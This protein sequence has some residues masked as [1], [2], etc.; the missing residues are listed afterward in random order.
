MTDTPPAIPAATLVVFRDAGDGPP[1]LLF[2]ER[3]KAMAFAGGALV[4]PG[5]RVD[6]GDHALAAVLGTGD[7]ESAARIA[8]VRETIEEAG[9]PIGLSAMPSPTAFARMRAALHA[10]TAF[11]EALT[12]AAVGLDLDALEYFARWRPAHAHARIFDT[13][14][15]LA[16]LPAGA[17]EA[18]VDATENVRL[19]WATAA[20]VLAEADAG[21]A[22]IIFPTRRNLERLTQFAD[23]AAAVEH[24][25]AHPVRTVTPWTETRDGVEHLCIP[26]DLGYPI[27]SEPMSDAVRG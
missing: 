1:E 3:A 25:R 9:L 10:G 12:D 11:G 23:C 6:P 16:R 24:A 8:A 26:H 7:A 4:F 13:R 5:G 22:T 17:P 15:Y 14:F 21:R 18:Q 27:T 19:F 2:V 20:D